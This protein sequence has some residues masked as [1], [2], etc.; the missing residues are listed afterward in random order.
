MVGRGDVRVLVTGM[1]QSRAQSAISSVLAETKPCCVVT[2]G[3]A[4]GLN[5]DFPRG[6]VLFDADE[7]F[8]IPVARLKNAGAFPACFHCAKRVVATAAEKSALHREIGADAVE[9]ESA[10]IRAACRAAGVPSATVRVISD[11]ADEDLP[12]DFNQ[13]MT[14]EGDMNYAR[15]AWAVVKSP[16]KIGE[17]RRFQQRILLAAENLAVALSGFTRGG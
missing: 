16:S 11:A 3:F 17:L 2:A 8:P 13:F 14:T 9:M 1:G 10:V 7:P 4:G 5:P 15:L 6:A 12:L